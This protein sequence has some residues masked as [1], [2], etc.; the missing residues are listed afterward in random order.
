MSINTQ[1]Q[2]FRYLKGTYLEPIIERS[3][4]H[5]R[6]KKLFTYTK[7]IRKRLSEKFAQFTSVFVIDSIPTPICKHSRAGRSNICSTYEIQ[8]SFG[9]CATQKSKYYGLNFM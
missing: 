1:L 9:H 5:K 7:S 6:R 8:P 4:Y 2:L 3:V